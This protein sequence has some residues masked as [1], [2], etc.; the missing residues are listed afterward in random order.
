MDWDELKKE[1]YKANDDPVIYKV[2]RENSMTL[3]GWFARQSVVKL[4]P[5]VETFAEASDGQIK[6]AIKTVDG[7]A[8]SIADAM[9]EARK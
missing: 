8:Y 4:L 3:R 7:A 5:P 6:S 1:L 9:L 2:M